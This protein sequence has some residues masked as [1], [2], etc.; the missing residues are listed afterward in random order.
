MNVRVITFLVL[1]LLALASLFTG[2]I[3]LFSTGMSKGEVWALIGDSRWPRTAATM[4]T[5]ASLAIAGQIMQLIARNRFVEP[6]TAGTGQSAALGV[7]LVVFFLP[8]AGIATKMALASA[9]ALF[10]SLGFFAIIRRLPPTQPLLVPLVGLVYGG[11]IGSGVTYAAYQADMLQY[12]DIWMNGEFSG[13]MRGR[14]ELL[15][16]AGLAA[17]VSY[18]IADQLSILGLGEE[19]SLNLG[20]KYQQ[21][22][23]AGL[24]VISVITGLTVV[25][26]GMIPFV[27]LVVPNIVSR[28]SGDNLRRSLPVTAIFGASLVLGADFLGRLIIHPFEVPVGTIVGVVGAILFLW[29][30]F[31]KGRWLA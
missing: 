15:W 6:M 14:Y 18:L 12:L 30:M 16:I 23:L 28:T 19:I 25:T 10:G 24:I 3:D 27:G 20:L 26:V 7:L 31:G 17:A 4:L 5:G 8:G 11:V 21:V 1:G 13:T 22:V 29:L 9:T 2:A